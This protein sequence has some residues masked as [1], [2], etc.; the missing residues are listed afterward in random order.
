MAGIIATSGIEQSSPA[1]PHIGGKEEEA[2]ASLL[3]KHRKAAEGRHDPLL[4][5]AVAG[6][7]V[8]GL[9]LHREFLH[10]EPESG[11]AERV[12]FG[13]QDL[14]VQLLFLGKRQE[15]LLRRR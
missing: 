5:P 13:P 15:H 6:P 12:D 4:C 1:D 7:T 11:L 8:S 14:H 2:C 10:V 3:P 9:F